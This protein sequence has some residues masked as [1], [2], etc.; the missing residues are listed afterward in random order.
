MRGATCQM[1]LRMCVYIKCIVGEEVSPS[2]THIP[3]T[4]THTQSSETIGTA[5][6]RHHIYTDEE[7]IAAHQEFVYTHCQAVRPD[8]AL[9]WV[10]MRGELSPMG[11]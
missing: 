5:K 2:P 10:S 7:Q 4:H 8:M 3:H 11:P 6:V 1:S 9:G